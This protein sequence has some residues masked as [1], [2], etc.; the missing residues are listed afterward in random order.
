M[1]EKACTPYGGD[2]DVYGVYVHRRRL[3]TRADAVRGGGAGT[4]HVQ[5]FIAPSLVN[6]YDT[7]KEE[8]LHSRQLHEGQSLLK[9]WRIHPAGFKVAIIVAAMPIGF[10]ALDRRA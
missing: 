4:E 9:C 5:H 10:I 3:Y 8:E 1:S 6:P 7:N 2:R